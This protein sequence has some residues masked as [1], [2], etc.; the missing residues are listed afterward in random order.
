MASG[1]DSGARILVVDD[2]AGMR[3]FLSILLQREGHRVVAAANGKEALRLAREGRFDL[4]ISDIR[5]P[6]LDGVGLLEGLREADPEMPVILITAF[7]SASS[8]IEAMKQGA[9]DYLTKPFK[10]E[11]IKGVV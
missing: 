8:T 11:E 6:Q 4:A 2:E 5:M 10:V 1:K 3:D 9:F 7:A